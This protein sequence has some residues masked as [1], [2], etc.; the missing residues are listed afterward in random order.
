[1]YLGCPPT[2]CINVVFKFFCDDCITHE[3]LKAKV[4]QNSG[5]EGG[6]Q[7][8]REMEK[9]KKEFYSGTLIE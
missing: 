9:W 7:G 1:M 5:G 8:I 2:F 4:L 3:T 6:K